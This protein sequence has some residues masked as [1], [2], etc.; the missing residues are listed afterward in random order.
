MKKNFVLSQ[1]FKPVGCRK[2]LITLKKA[3]PR[4]FH[5]DMLTF[6]LRQLSHWEPILDYI[7]LKQGHHFG[8]SSLLMV[9]TLFPPT[10]WW[11]VTQFY[12]QGYLI[13]L[14]CDRF[15]VTRLIIS[16][17]IYISIISTDIFI[18]RR[19][20]FSEKKNW[21][22][23]KGLERISDFLNQKPQNNRELLWALCLLIPG[24]I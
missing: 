22:T 8:L 9:L 19:I 12:F 10:F 16:T 13:S 11:N 23:M 21:V 20:Q 15:D 1:N 4:V 18:S 24:F 3:F 5:L 17:D 7:L 6:V 2:S 14:N